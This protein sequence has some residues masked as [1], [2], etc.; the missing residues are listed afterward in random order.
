M[1]TTR[2]PVLVC[3]WLGSREKIVSKLNKI[4]NGSDDLED[5]LTVL[6]NYAHPFMSNT[7]YA[8]QFEL[9]YGEDGNESGD[10]YFGLSLTYT[11]NQ[12]IDTFYKILKEM[13]T[14]MCLFSEE[15]IKEKPTFH[16]V[17]YWY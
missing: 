13:E 10:T 9:I 3:G 7:K 16:T 6:E 14:I 1:S 8:D 17:I 5:A 4:L 11:N 15:Y 12:S 2:S